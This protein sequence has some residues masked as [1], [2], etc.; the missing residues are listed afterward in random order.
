M[1]DTKVG[2]TMEDAHKKPLESVSKPKGFKL[3]NFAKDE[4][5]EYN[6][7]WVE[8][9]EGFSL[10]IARFNNPEHVELLRKRQKSEL[11]SIVEITEETIKDEDMRAILRETMAQFVL[12]DW[13]GLLDDDDQLI[14]FSVD[15]AYKALHHD[16][17]FRVCFQESKR[18]ENFK[19]SERLESV[20]N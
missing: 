1:T 18:I 17:F 20:G 3:S 7:A 9:S 8:Y 12:K 14:Q 15:E 11:R 5:L 19:K 4:D 16:D 6:G 13:K 2:L 10:R